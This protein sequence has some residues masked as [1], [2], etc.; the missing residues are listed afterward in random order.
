M[1]SAAQGPITLAEQDLA[2]TLADC[3]AFQEWLGVA[4]R[5]EALAR[6]YF[7]GLPKPSN[8]RESY[9]AKELKTLRPYACIWTDD[10]AG[11]RRTLASAGTAYGFRD[12]GRLHLEFVQEV[13]AAN[14]DD[15]DEADRQFKISL[16]L[17]VDDLSELAG[18][19]GYLIVAGLQLKGPLRPHPDAEEGEGPWQWAKLIIDWGL[20]A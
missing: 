8:G 1:T 16:G 2:N 19:P 4:T 12:N 20:G 17:I 15:L 9:T 10:D 5:E 18:Q 14:V 7:D 11:F 3:H 6:I 13:A